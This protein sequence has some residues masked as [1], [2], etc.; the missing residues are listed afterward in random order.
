MMTDDRRP[1]GTLIANYMLF[2][3]T[4]L[5]HRLTSP[6]LDIT[7]KAVVMVTDIDEA[8]DDLYTEISITNQCGQPPLDLRGYLQVRDG[9]GTKLCQV[10][11]KRAVHGAD[12]SDI[13]LDEIW[14]DGNSSAD[15]LG[16]FWTFL[17]S[18]KWD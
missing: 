8:P 5:D 13:E 4:L 14:L 18:G 2:R 12:N 6:D 17:V 1:F 3:L 16:R 9:S 15:Y 11:V 10:M 7:S